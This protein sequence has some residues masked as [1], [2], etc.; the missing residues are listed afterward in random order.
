MNCLEKMLKEVQKQ[1]IL[2]PLSSSKR[3]LLEASSSISEKMIRWHQTTIKTI[4]KDVGLKGA[5][6]VL[7]VFQQKFAFKSV[8]KLHL[9]EKLILY[10]T[11]ALLCI[12]P[13]RQNERKLN[14]LS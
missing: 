1:Q 10:V 7:T 9:S 3:S 5:N 13:M 11:S 8:E 14:K 12:L 6:V 4:Q 2:C